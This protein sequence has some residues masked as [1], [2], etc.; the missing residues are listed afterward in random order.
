METD[1]SYT[2][3]LST[4]YANYF[5]AWRALFGEPVSV[6]PPTSSE[7]REQLWESEGG[8]LDAPARKP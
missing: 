2:Q 7:L 8:S 4:L 6:A 1:R 5:D 3:K